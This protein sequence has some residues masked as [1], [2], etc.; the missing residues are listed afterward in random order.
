MFFLPTLKYDKDLKKE[1]KEIGYI[2]FNGGCL[3]F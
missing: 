3:F 2:A 1:H